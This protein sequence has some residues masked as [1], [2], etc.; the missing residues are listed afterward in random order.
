ME[1]SVTNEKRQ[2]PRVVV[3]C[4][5]RVFDM[6]NRLLVK[7]KTVDIA[8]GGVKI[9]GPAVG[10]P[11]PGSNVNVK[12]DLILPDSRKLRQIERRATIRRVEAMGDW[13]AVALEFAKQVE[14]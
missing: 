4:P 13:T 9:M 7:G 2:Y 11:E 1:P 3:A 6:Q 14:V 12:I 10:E 8:A 5:A